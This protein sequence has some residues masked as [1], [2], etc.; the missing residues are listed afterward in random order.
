[1]PHLLLM[2]WFKQWENYKEASGWGTGSHRIQM[3]YL[4][5]VL[6][7]EIRTAIMFDHLQTVAEAMEAIMQYLEMAVMPLCLRRLE[8]LC[9][10]PPAGQSQTVTTQTVV[11]MFREARMWDITPDDLMTICL[12]NTVQ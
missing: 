5:P 3:A 1:M 10:K 4:C 12:L 8:V 7:D 6:S 9:Y 11:Q 2:D